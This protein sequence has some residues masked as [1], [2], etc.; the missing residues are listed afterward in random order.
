M[1]EDARGQWLG[2]CRS[3]AQPGLATTSLLSSFTTAIVVACLCCESP[4]AFTESFLQLLSPSLVHS[5]PQIRA[6]AFCASDLRNMD[7]SLDDIISE[8]PVCSNRRHG[9]IGDDS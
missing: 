5:C 7:R 3:S 8:R 1:D 6:Q 9:V 4:F 2:G